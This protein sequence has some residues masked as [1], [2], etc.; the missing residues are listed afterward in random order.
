M[1]VHSPISVYWGGAL[2]LIGAGVIA[3]SFLSPHEPPP[4]E[5]RA[6]NN[7]KSHEVTPVDGTAFRYGPEINHGR[8]DTP[9][10]SAALALKE[11]KASAPSDPRSAMV[12]G[13]YQRRSA[14]RSS[15]T[16]FY[17]RGLQSG[18]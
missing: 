10:N 1:P 15:T 9:V 17:N 14:Y 5:G 3:L 16:N 7:Q 4:L 13:M 6:A 2:A 12:P 11:A 8:S 18:Q